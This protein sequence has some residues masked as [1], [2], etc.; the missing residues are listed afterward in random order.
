MS[1]TAVM[2]TWFGKTACNDIRLADLKREAK[3]LGLSLLRNKDKNTFMKA[4]ASCLIN[5]K[6]VEI[7]AGV[8]LAKVAQDDVLVISK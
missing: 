2:L 6:K 5:K 4:V 7:A 3:V 1:A 8:D